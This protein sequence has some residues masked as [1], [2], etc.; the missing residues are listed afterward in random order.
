MHLANPANEGHHTTRP[1]LKDVAALAHTSV[2]TAS[3]V[4]SGRDKFVSDSLTER[5]KEAASALGYRPNLVA[6]S[7]KGKSRNLVA[8]LVPEFW[9]P[10]FTRI[11]TG[12]ERVAAQNGYLPLICSTEGDARRQEEYIEGIVAQQVDGC[13]L[14]PVSSDP[15]SLGAV[16][17]SGIPCVVLDRP[18]RN[19]FNH[20]SVTYDMAGAAGTVVNYLARRGHR[21]IGFIGW[22]S[23]AVGAR[24]EG[25]REATRALRL[26]DEDCPILTGELTRESGA[27]LVRECLEAGKEHG[28]ITALLLGHHHLG[29]GAVMEL[30]RAGIR[31]PDDLSVVVY[32]NPT[33]AQMMHPAFTCVDLPDA[34]MG[35]MAMEILIQMLRGRPPQVV[36]TVLP[37]TLV[38]RGSVRTVSQTNERGSDQDD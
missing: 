35:K 16:V 2:A 23:P 4:L 7:M 5:V 1:T 22:N 31:W 3:N 19:P 28:G 10:V 13:L 6:R 17:A 27:R 15:D 14:T 8:I 12:A 32:G 36:H 29:E 25:F 24:A 20:P 38:E 33:W 26:P 11:V 9:N 21:R 18:L 37:C 30:A 34:D